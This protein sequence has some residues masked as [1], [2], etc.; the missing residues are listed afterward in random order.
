MWLANSSAAIARSGR[1]AAVERAASAGTKRQTSGMS[2]RPGAPAARNP[3]RQPQRAATRPATANPASTPSCEP[4]IKIAIAPAR[5]SGAYL[6]AITAS[7]TGVVPASPMPTST[8]AATSC[9]QE[10]TN[11]V[12]VVASANSAKAPV[13]VARPPTRAARRAIGSPITA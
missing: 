4:I 10:A 5:R 11:A 8:R 1:R 9:V 13:I 3:A 6:C 2:A 12:A 7:D